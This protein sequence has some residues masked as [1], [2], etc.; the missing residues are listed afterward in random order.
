VTS[1]YV[2]TVDSFLL[3]AADKV[4]S[5]IAGAVTGETGKLLKLPA[6]GRNKART[7]V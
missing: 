3:A 7:R 1:G 6:E 2:A 4:A 5:Y